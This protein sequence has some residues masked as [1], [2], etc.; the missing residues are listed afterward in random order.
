MQE[1]TSV[2]VRDPRMQREDFWHAYM[3]YEIC[4]HTNSPAFT[5]KTSCVRRRYSEFVWLRQRLQNNVLL[6]VRVPELPPKNPFFSM[7]NS[8]HISVRMEGLR[9]FLEEVLRRPVLL[10]DS[11]LHLFLQSPLSVSQ[12]EACADG[13][14]RCSV[15][16]AILSSPAVLRFGPKSQEEAES[17]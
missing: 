6:I 13:R 15:S 3:D 8:R 7:N 14:T 2:W 1:F 5:K 9:N 10:S 16:Q 4:I 11:C 17:E 12:M